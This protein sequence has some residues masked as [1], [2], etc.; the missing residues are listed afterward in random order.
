MGL[1]DPVRN[2]DPCPLYDMALFH[3]H[4]QEHNCE[5]SI[6]KQIWKHAVCIA[7]SGW[8]EMCL[9]LISLCLATLTCRPLPSVHRANTP[10][11]VMRMNGLH[12]CDVHIH[13]PLGEDI[14]LLKGQLPQITFLSSFHF[15]SF[16]FLFQTTFA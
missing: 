3:M 1:S 7:E 11:G 2:N 5:F 15:F 4:M 9:I 13:F 16:F 6:A 12:V 14:F 8:G 10:S